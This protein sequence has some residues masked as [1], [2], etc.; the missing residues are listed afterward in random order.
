MKNQDQGFTLVEVIV[1][2]A[3]IGILISIVGIGVPGYQDFMDK[4]DLKGETKKLYYSL[5]E[6]RN[7]AIM[8]GNYRTV[9]L[10]E[11]TNKI[12]IR[13]V[14]EDKTSMIELSKD[15][16]VG[17]T[18]YQST[19]GKNIL[20]RLYPDGTMSPGGRIVLESPREKYRTIIIQPVSGR[21]YIEEGWRK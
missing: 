16:I 11:D 1:V 17:Y 20:L 8:E 4:Q 21:T 6:A 13:N 10:I 14:F 9:Q 19:Y 12:F 15:I 2:L 18:T 5:L 7:D 3:I